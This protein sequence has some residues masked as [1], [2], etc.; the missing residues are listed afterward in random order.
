[1]KRLGTVLILLLAFAGLA[2]SL[3]LAEHKITG[4]PLICNV[5]NLTGCNVVANS[6]YSRIFGLPIADAGVLFFASLF[7]IAAL[8][9]IFSDRLLRRV[10]QVGATLGVCMSI[11]LAI[12]QV[13]VIKAL[14]IYCLASGMIMLIIFIIAIFLEPL[15]RIAPELTP[16]L[17]PVSP[18]TNFLRDTLTMPP[19]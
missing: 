3:Y 13:F 6:E 19:T 15:R 1:M 9:L 8:E 11:F 4:D 16:E 10:L 14:C 18:G 7:V 12:V 2:D 17:E 5:Q